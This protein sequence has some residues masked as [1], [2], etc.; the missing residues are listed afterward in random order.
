MDPVVIGVVVVVVLI[1]GTGLF[2]WIRRRSK[3]VEEED[4]R[5]ACPSCRRKLKYRKRQR[6]Q[7][8][9]CPRCKHVFVFPAV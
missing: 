5:Y 9:M 7:K 8:G 2:I 3:P 6:G 4:F 1:A